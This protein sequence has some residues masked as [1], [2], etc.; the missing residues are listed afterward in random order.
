MNDSTNQLKISSALVRKAI[1]SASKSGGF[2]LETLE[3]Y[4]I[5]LVP[6]TLIVSNTWVSSRELIA[7]SLELSLIANGLIN[8]QSIQLTCFLIFNI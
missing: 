7:F 4:L 3:G 2:I 6:W 8:L 5:P 1:N